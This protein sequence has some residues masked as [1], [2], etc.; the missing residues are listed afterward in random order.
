MTGAGPKTVELAY[1]RDAGPSDKLLWAQLAKTTNVEDFAA[2]WLQMQARALGEVR[3]GVLIMG[4]PETGPFMPVA[5]WPAGRGV[6]PELSIAAE[7][8]LADRR[9]VLRDQPAGTRSEASQ[10]V[11]L[12][13]IFDDALYGVVAFDLEPRSPEALAE[14]G[15]R[16]HWGTAWIE[17]LV[18]RRSLLPNRQ[19]VE[20]LETVAAVLEALR[21]DVALQGLALDVARVLKAEWAGCGLAVRGHMR[22]A[23]LSQAITT[24]RRQQI[25]AATAAAMQEA[26][27]QQSALQVPEEPGASPRV[28]RAHRA[29]AELASAPGVMSLP[30]LMESRITGILTVVARSGQE[31]SARDR[32]FVRL[33]GTLVGPAIS[34][35]QRDDRWIGA[36]VAQSAG[37]V[38][39]KLVG[40]R[41]VPLKL[42]AVAVLA[43]A[44]WLSVATATY[45]VTAPAT[46]E[47]S[48]QRA[49]T[50][51]IAGFVA[52]QFARAGDHVAQGDLLARLDDRE[53]RLD[54]T[55]LASERDQR[56]SEY[57]RALAQGDRDQVQV[58]KA[59]IEQS[60]ARLDLLDAQI[61]K[62]E[63]RAPIAGMIV[64]GDLSKMIGAPVQRGDVLFEIAPL[65]DYRIIL[66]V[67]ER[68]AALVREGQTGTLVLASLSALPLTLRVT[69]WTPISIAE[70]GHNSFRVEAALDGANPAVRPG[71]QGFGKIDIGERGVARIATARLAQWLRMTAW[72]FWF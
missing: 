61:A 12:P 36:K 70:G 50:V 2:L 8:A 49:V 4:V 15:R 6:G 72:R 16:L 55:R 66:L 5:Q 40:P 24:S 56:L 32:D 41:Q 25:M 21:L 39:Q 18:R 20:V 44:A 22:V 68:D 19:L 37:A 52:G 13:L 54:R 38:L 31:F 11:A 67:D 27:D 33:L 14:A 1:D 53:F 30:V 59:E 65:D 58:L 71:M 45:R 48:V 47:G 69:K 35:R 23:A 34:L 62:V 10:C 42:V 51:P 43:A 57:K 63:L 60:Q 17:A 28:T 46:V 29:L 64:R 7:T 3:L 26:L 9:G